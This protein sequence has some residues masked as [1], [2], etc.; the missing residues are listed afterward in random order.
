LD[1]S[2]VAGGIAYV[3]QEPSLLPWRTSLQNACLGLELKGALNQDRVQSVRDSLEEYGLRGFE[4]S[5]PG[6]LSGGMRQRISVIRALESNP[7]LML[8]DE[9]FS[10]IDFVTR[11]DLNTR[12]KRMCRVNAITTIFVTHNIE[13]AIFLADE[14]AVMSGRPGRIVS[15]YRPRLSVAPDDAVKSRS[16]PEFAKYFLRIWNDL[17]GLNAESS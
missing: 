5:L 7:Q 15:S 6:E 4:Q 17:K 9:P 8:C 3:P 2:V 1:R 12:F 16:S 11:L 14:V 10:A 13:E